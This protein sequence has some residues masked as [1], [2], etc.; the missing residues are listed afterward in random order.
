MSDDPATTLRIE[1]VFAGTAKQRL[2]SLT[3]AEGTTV[4]EA[5]E[6]SGLQQQFPGTDLAHLDAGVWG[7]PVERTRVLRDGDRV[8]IY[9]PLQMDPREARRK[10]AEHGQAMGQKSNDT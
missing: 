5:I 9:R 1:V 8:E 2:L 7:Q 4:A 10:L 6:Q 3:V